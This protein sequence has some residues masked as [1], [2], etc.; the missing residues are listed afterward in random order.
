MTWQRWS[1]AWEQALY[2]PD[3]FYVRGEVPA[4]HF[5]TSTHSGDA[6]ARLVLEV[7]TDVD[8]GLGHPTSLDVVDV[9]A[10]GGELLTRLLELAHDSLRTR[11]AL[12]GVDYG[13][14]PPDLPSSVRW[15]AEVPRGV[16]GLLIGNE[17]LDNVP[18]HVVAR[19]DAGLLRELEVEVATG[20]ERLGRPA[21]VG[22]DTWCSLWWH[23][24]AGQRAEVGRDRDR[25]WAQ[26]LTR[27]DFGCAVAID[28]AHTRASR[29]ATLTGFRDGRQVPPVPD[30]SCDITAH[31]ALDSCASAGEDLTGLPPLLVLQHDVLR[32]YAM[33]GSLPA[34][35]LAK[36]DPAA[37]V[38]ALQRAN[39][40][41]ELLDAHG[42]GGFTWLVQPVGM[43]MPPRLA[44][45]R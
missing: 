31:V 20:A 2:G 8:D 43:P 42:L 18:C 19:D 7:L 14:R 33:N 37:Y 24:D 41:A 25:A 1:V 5:R 6:L 16:L 38:A 39:H 13:P 29:R 45:L 15:S 3:G 10:G 44:A 12:T 32:A 27:I 35:D 26:A 11:L 9:G 30:R 21:V 28:Y 34:V 23:L 22:D 4:R 17:W 40:E 36:T